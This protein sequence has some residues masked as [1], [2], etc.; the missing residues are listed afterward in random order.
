MGIRSLLLD[1]RSE[2][3]G[4]QSDEVIVKRNLKADDW[5]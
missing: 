3:F 5:R 2:H 4:G 1:F